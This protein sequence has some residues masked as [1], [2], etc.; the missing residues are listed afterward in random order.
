MSLIENSSCFKNIC[1]K[2][3]LFIKTVNP[4]IDFIVVLSSLAEIVYASDFYMYIK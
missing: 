4:W 3:N 1:E 2:S